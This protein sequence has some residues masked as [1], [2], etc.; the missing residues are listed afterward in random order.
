MAICLEFINF[1]V[2]IEVIKKKYP[3]GWAAC[4]EDHK[5]LIGGRVWYDVHLFR[6]GAMNPNDMG[7]LVDEWREL[8][9]QIDEES[10]GEKIFKDCLCDR[11]TFRAFPPV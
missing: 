6:D 9:F 11:R 2:P 1:V 7:R 5:N 4:L 8:G 10:D 3:G